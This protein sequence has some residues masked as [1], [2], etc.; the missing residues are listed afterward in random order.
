MARV[1]IVDD[2]KLIRNAAS[3]MLG[4]EF[5]VVTADDGAEAWALLERD[6]S[7]QVVFTDLAM[8]GLNGYELLRNIRTSSDSRIRALP[9]IVVTGVEDD[10]VARVRALE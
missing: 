3:K 10:E 7:I 8:P 6:A 1:L 9:T 4:A 2:S 5:D